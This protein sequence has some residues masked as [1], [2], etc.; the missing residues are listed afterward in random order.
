M[1]ANDTTA[2]PVADMFPGWVESRVGDVEGVSEARVE[3][4]WD[5]PWTPDMLSD[6]IKLELGLL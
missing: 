2:C 4:V 1:E 6:E 3:L 5:P